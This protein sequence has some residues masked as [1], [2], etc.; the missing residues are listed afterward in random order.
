MKKL[1]LVFLSVTLYITMMAQDYWSMHTSTAKIITDKSV[2][3]KSFPTNYKLFDLD[4]AP[5]KKDLFS[6][7]SNAAK[8]SVI[9]SI[10]NAVGKLEQF[11]VMEAS[12]FDHKLQAR[13]PMIRAFSG[14][15]ITDKYATLK[16][17]ISP[18]GIQTMVFRTDNENEFIESYSGDHK[19]Y[20][21]FKI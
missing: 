8:H 11:E 14:R 3:R 17:S 10:P 12:N 7:V 2:A 15:G 19:T 6:V 16:L 4:I 13:F 18:Q 9:I 20:A 5:L 1:L 21:V